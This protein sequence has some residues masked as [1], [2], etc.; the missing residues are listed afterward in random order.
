M[1]SLKVLQSSDSSSHCMSLPWLIYQ[2]WL[3]CSTGFGY[4]ASL[5]KT[6]ILNK[7]QVAYYQ[8]SLFFFFFFF[9][10]PVLK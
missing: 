2:I 3:F 4:R 1:P 10:F 7:L 8:L 5:E 6:R 9:P